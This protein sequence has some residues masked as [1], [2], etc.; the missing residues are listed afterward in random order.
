MVIN[1]KIIGELI[2]LACTTDG[3]EHLINEAATTVILECLRDDGPTDDNPLLCKIENI[4]RNMVPDCYQCAAPCGKNGAYDVDEMQKEIPVVRDLKHSILD[5]LIRFAKTRQTLSREE[6]SLLYR[7]LILLGI[8]QMSED[9]L[10]SYQT[11]LLDL[12]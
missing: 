10:H 6:E 4:K 11:Q 2:G 8:N 12:L 3:N 7:S 5:A 9:I 1:K